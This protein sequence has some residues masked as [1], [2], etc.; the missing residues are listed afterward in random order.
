M[1]GEERVTDVTQFYA[2]FSPVFYLVPP[3]GGIFNLES[4]FSPTGLS[5]LSL[6]GAKKKI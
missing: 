4:I 1:E 5:I 6:R 2:D 3:I